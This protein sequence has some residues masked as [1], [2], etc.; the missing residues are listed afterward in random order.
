MHCFALPP[1]GQTEL[2]CRQANRKGR[3]EAHGGMVKFI[4]DT[5][6]GMITSMST[7]W[8]MRHPRCL[9]LS[10]HL[11]LGEDW[12]RCG[13]RASPLSSGATKDFLRETW[14]ERERLRDVV[15]AMSPHF[16]AKLGEFRCRR[17]RQR[18]RSQWARNGSG[19]DAPV[20][21]A[22]GGWMDH[23]K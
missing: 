20:A 9:S 10:K 13:G 3:G 18:Q 6:L 19:T 15:I 22:A 4:R 16:V 7:A 17:V 5:P 1:A 14:E 11:L 12:S 8:I 21:A 2:Q 23:R